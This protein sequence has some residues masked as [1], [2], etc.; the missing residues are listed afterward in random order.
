[1]TQDPKSPPQPAV[2]VEQAHLTGYIEQ[3]GIPETKADAIA[4]R[5]MWVESAAMF[6]RNEEY[7]RGLLDQIAETIGPEAWKADNGDIVDDE[8]VRARLPELVHHRLSAA[9]KAPTAPIGELNAD[10]ICAG[11]KAWIESTPDIDL[12]PRMMRD[13]ADFILGQPRATAPIGEAGDWHPM[14]EAPRDGSYILAIVSPNRGRHLEHQ[15][16]RVFSIRHEGVTEPSGYDMG[17]AVYPGFGG[18]SDHDFTHWRP[19][20]APPAIRAAPSSQRGD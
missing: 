10:R 8:P 13:A 7:Y 9:P 20:P 6:S 17:W 14:S 15:A 12:S 4:Q 2:S 1:M 11:L 18:A 5:D 16:G 3:L 19:L